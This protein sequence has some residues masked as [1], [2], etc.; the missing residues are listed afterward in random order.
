MQQEQSA[1]VRRPWKW[2]ITPLV[3]TFAL[4]CTWSP[5]RGEGASA[6]AEGPRDS[7][8]PTIRH[9][10]PA[11]DSIGDLPPRFEW[12]PVEGADRYTIG[13]WN[14]VDRLLWRQEDVH[15]TSIDR[16]DLLDLDSGTYFW[17]V[18]ALS[19]SRQVADSG[20]SAFVVRR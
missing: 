2:A 4:A 9:L 17:R 18:Q 8:A 13:L 16:P 3:V 15:A 19:D 10:V 1:N 20:W 5:D 7:S 12:T 14:D 6:P 11:A